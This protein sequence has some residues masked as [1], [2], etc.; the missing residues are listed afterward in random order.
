MHYLDMENFYKWAEKQTIPSKNFDLQEAIVNS[1]DN[2]CDVPE[3]EK[4]E[5]AKSTFQNY[6]DQ[7]CSFFN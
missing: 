6:V 4:L 2:A 7:G 5:C 1:I 3:A